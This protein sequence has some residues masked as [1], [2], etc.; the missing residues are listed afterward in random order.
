VSQ[1]AVDIDG[2]IV[3][4]PIDEGGD[5]KLPQFCHSWTGASCDWEPNLHEMTVQYGNG[6]FNE[7]FQAYIT[8]DVSTFY[9]ESIGSKHAVKPSFTGQFGKFINLSPN[10]V[11]VHWDSGR[12]GDAPVYIADIA[13][14][15]SAGT[16]TFPTHKFIVT[17]ANDIKKILIQW[18]I[19]PGNSLYYYDPFDN[20]PEKAKKALTA[21]QYH[22]Y[23][24]QIQNRAFAHQYRQFTG[25]D[26]LA[27]YKHKHPPR[28]HM[29]RADS[30]GQTHTVTTEEIHFTELPPE[31]ELKRGTSAYGP[32][33]DE[34]ARMRRFRHQDPS[35]ELHLRAISCA[36]RV[37]EIRNFLSDVEV[38]HILQIANASYMARSSTKAGDAALA[39]SSDSTRTSKNTWISRNHDM[40]LD[41]IHR[42][43]ADILQIPESL[44]RWRRKTEIPEFTESLITI[45]EKLQLVHYDVGQRTYTFLLL[46]FPT[47][48]CDGSLTKT[49][50]Y[51]NIRRITI[52]PCRVWCTVSPVDLPQYCFT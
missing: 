12:R 25:T 20:N 11:R 7:S 29:W 38:D 3:E 8:P 47:L 37:F 15:G 48:D 46:S 52:F 43:A 26:W 36:P 31:E 4:D 28:Y 34:I 50:L 14:F 21:D 33:P 45:A 5:A 39:T 41:A 16:A 40:I 44:L 9:N 24:I 2:N 32:R 13:P 6:I 23:Y 22:L 10:S 51:Q 19:E 17:P 1:E 49:F 27:L 42:R 35:M 18:T 30:F